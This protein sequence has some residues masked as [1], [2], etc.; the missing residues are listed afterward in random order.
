M[1]ANNEIKEIKGIKERAQERKRPV[2]KCQ[3]GKGNRCER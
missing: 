3:L 2:D 1:N